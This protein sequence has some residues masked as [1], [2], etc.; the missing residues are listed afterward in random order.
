M[1]FLLQRG[2]WCLWQ[3]L[4][5]SPF[6]FSLQLSFILSRHSMWS[7]FLAAAAPWRLFI[8]VCLS[9]FP[10]ANFDLTMIIRI[11]HLCYLWKIYLMQSSD[12]VCGSHLK[13]ALENSSLRPQ[14]SSLSR[15]IFAEK[16]LSYGEISAF[17]VWQLWGNWKFLHMRQNFRRLHMADVEKSEILHT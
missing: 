17:H 1:F 13:S 2:G 8:F 4:E 6:T 7:V 14:S 12:R 3:Y 10:C 5:H 11:E 15:I 16:K 9:R